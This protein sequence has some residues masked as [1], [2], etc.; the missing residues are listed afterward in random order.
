M[1]SI[2]ELYISLLIAI[3]LSIALGFGI[4]LAIRLDSRDGRSVKRRK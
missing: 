4:C 1:C 3:P 2:H